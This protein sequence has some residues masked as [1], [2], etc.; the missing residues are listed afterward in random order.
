[1]INGTQFIAALGCE[2]LYR[3]KLIADQSDIVA[4]LSIDVLKG[5]PNAF[6]RGKVV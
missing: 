5:T 4:A 3:A 2:A 6:D 1:M